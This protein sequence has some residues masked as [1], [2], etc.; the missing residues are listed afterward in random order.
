MSRGI[1]HIIRRAQP[2]STSAVKAH[3]KRA[4]QISDE[5]ALRWGAQHRHPHHWKLKHI[6]WYLQVGCSE[7]SAATQYDHW[8]TV[9]VVL[10][11][12]GRWPTWEPRLRG[13]WCH[14]TGRPGDGAGGRPVKLA[15]RSS[16]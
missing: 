8:R 12:I 11:A 16:S 14:R 5:L 6:R 4:E 7:L 13:P 1:T 15:H 9:R 2:G 10:A 3:I